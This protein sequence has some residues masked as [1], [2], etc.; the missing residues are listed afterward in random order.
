[1]PPWL[2]LKEQ[3][4]V[5]YSLGQI[6][7]GDVLPSIRSLAAQLSI[8]EAMVRRAYQELIA[9]GLVSALERKQ[10]MVVDS[11]SSPV[12]AKRLVDEATE[13]CSGL[14]HWATKRGV[15]SL[16]LARFLRGL[17]AS[18][19][20]VQPSYAYV[21]ASR[22]AA[23]EF[24]GFIARAWEVKIAAYSLEEIAS[25]PI[26]QLQRFCAVLVNY[27]RFEAVRRGLPSSFTR[28]FPIRLRLSGRLVRRM[29]RLPAQSRILLLFSQADVD[30][31][32]RLVVEMHT[33]TVGRNWSFECRALERIGDVGAV[34]ETGVYRLIIVSVH[35]W[36]QISERARR[37]SN[38]VCSQYEPEVQSLEEIRLKAGV[39]A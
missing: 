39:L 31:M 16:G 1:L 37:K 30:R 10:Y 27:V 12:E 14:I 34:A 5:A 11:L 22:P 13:R 7:P 9:L 4:K 19:E 28:L 26:E 24:A 3:I 2:Q 25:L 33:T 17:A 23:E 29:R 6:K 18:A 36:D 32:G 15:S 38:V 20:S 8:G 35:V 21:S